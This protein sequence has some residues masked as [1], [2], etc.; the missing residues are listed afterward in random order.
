ML[1]QDNFLYILYDELIKTTTICLEP[2]YFMKYDDTHTGL[3]FKQSILQLLLLLSIKDSNP[4]LV[5]YSMR[6]SFIFTKIL[7]DFFQYFVDAHVRC[8]IHSKF[9][10]SHTSIIQ[11]KQYVWVTLVCVNFYFLFVQQV[12]FKM[13]FFSLLHVKKL[14]SFSFT[15]R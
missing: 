10:T 1:L 8:S 5:L 2:K 14:L 13:L 4:I 12:D 3:F 7:Q 15:F 6:F 11:K 9:Q